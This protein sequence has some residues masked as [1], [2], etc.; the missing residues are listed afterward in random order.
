MIDSAPISFFLHSEEE[1]LS[2]NS[3]LQ[4]AAHLIRLYLINIISF[5]KAWPEVVNL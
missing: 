1:S 4:V 5:V 2:M 3:A